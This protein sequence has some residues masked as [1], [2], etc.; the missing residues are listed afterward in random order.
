MVKGSL[1]GRSSTDS[2]AS[3]SHTWELRGA[4]TNQRLSGVDSPPPRQSTHMFDNT[5]ESQEHQGQ[6]SVLTRSL[7]ASTTMIYP[8]SDCLSMDTLCCL[9]SVLLCLLVDWPHWRQDPVKHDAE[10]EA[11]AK[12]VTSNIFLI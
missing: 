5:R 7:Q 3:L 2:D 8:L 11:E 9:M 4:I 10:M 6:I 1:G 12:N